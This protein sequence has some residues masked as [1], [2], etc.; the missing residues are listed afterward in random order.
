MTWEEKRDHWNRIVSEA[1]KSHEPIR[2][3]CD[4]NCVRTNSFYRWS[5][6]LGYT[7]DGKKTEKC[8]ALMKNQSVGSPAQTGQASPMFVE[9]PAQVLGCISEMEDNAPSAR[10]LITI[11]AGGYQIGILDGFNELTLSKVLEV[12][13]YA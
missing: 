6:N 8:L 3:W 11:Q 5:K 1:Y 4:R 10:P 7:K 9:V 2:R 12:V 13:R